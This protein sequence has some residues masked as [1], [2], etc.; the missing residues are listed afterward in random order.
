MSQ[1]APSVKLSP[2]DD[3]VA[4]TLADMAATAIPL[5]RKGTSKSARLDN[6]RNDDVEIFTDAAVSEICVKL[7]NTTGVSCYGSAVALAGLHGHTWNLPPKSDYDETRLLLWQDDPDSDHWNWTPARDMPGSE[8]VEALRVV[9][10]K[11]VLTP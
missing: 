4:G 7:T 6:L 8:F 9:N 2:N 3:A 11:F 5:Y 10:G 1:M